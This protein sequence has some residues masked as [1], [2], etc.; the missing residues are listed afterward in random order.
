[1]TETHLNLL[2]DI[3]TILFIFHSVQEL[4]SSERTP[5]LA[6]TIPAYEFCLEMLHQLVQSDVFPHLNHAIL[7]AIDKIEKYVKIAR[8]N[9][10]Y[11]MSICKIFFT[12]LR[13]L[14]ASV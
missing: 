3:R 4:V 10:I 9:H 11:G 12:H 13:R 5:T 1:M 2:N 14:T 7:P 6:V 8:T